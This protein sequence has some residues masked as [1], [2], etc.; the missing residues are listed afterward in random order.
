MAVSEVVYTQYKV[1]QLKVLF[2]ISTARAHIFNPFQLL[3]V[4]VLLSNKV[5]FQLYK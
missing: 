5:G 2:V 1:F 3:L 4:I